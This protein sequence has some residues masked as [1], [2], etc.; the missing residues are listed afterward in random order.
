MV[1]RGNLSDPIIGTG[2]G[3]GTGT[4]HTEPLQSGLSDYWWLRIGL[5][6]AKAST[7]DNVAKVRK[8]RSALLPYHDVRMVESSIPST[9]L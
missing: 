4:G 2:T 5:I 8:I 7:P 9:L 1:F 6:L 3:T